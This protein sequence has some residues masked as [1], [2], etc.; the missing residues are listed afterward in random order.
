MTEPDDDDLFA[1]VDDL[2]ANMG[3]RYL[4]WAKADIAK[5]R[6]VLAEARALPGEGRASFVR[7][8]FAVAHDIKGQ[9]GSFGYALMTFLGDGLCRFVE[10]Q[11]RLDDNTLTRMDDYADAMET[12]IKR[13]LAGD[14]GADGAALK[15]R[16]S[17]E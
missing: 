11:A 17:G 9:G 5:L 2:V 3:G 12:V 8:I 7:P 4:D 14:G 13:R 10:A 15:A 1:A 6:A 16:F